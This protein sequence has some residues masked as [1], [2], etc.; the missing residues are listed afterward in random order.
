M[1]KNKKMKINKIIVI[2]AIISMYIKIYNYD[3]IVKPINNN[4]E[5]KGCKYN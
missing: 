4:K 2:L 5:I 3:I 1:H